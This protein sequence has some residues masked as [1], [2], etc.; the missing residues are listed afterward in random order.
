MDTVL[1]NSHELIS[2]N[3]FALPKMMLLPNI[4]LKHPF[5]L[6][7]IFPVILIVDNI[8]NRFMAQLSMEIE[9]T[10]KEQK[11][12]ESKRSQIEQFDMKNSAFLQITG[13]ESLNFTKGRWNELTTDIQSLDTKKQILKLISRY[14][15]ALYWLD[16]LGPMIECALAEMLSF[17]H[18]LVS[19]IMV[20]SRAIQ[21]SID[22]I[23]MKSRA[24]AE[25]ASLNSAIEKLDEYLILADTSRKRNLVDCS[26]TAGS[27]LSIEGLSFSRGSSKVYF[28]FVFLISIIHHITLSFQFRYRS[29]KCIFNL[30][31]ML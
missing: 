6:V 25:L 16:I 29:K 31:F 24:E 28:N 19:E 11:E 7:Q 4:V 17:G 20:F 9:K 18:I 23:L 8:K 14:L 10:S 13:Q 12:L 21:D 1:Q 30:V 26:L 22:F 15:R 2:R 27:F 3:C 5:L